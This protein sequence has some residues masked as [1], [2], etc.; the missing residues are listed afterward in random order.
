MPQFDGRSSKLS[1]GSFQSRSDRFGY[2]DSLRG[3]AALLVIYLHLAD[4]FLHTEPNLGALD[5]WSFVA[6]TEVIDIGK[7]AV[8]VFFAISGYVIPFSLMKRSDHAVRRFV[9]SR[10]FRLYPAYWLSLSAALVVLVLAA[11][12]HVDAPEVVAN[13][14]MLQQFFGIENVLGIYWTLQIELIFYALCVG[15]FIIGLLQKTKFIFSTSVIF[16]AFALVLAAVRFYSGMKL[17]VVVPLSLA[18]MFWGMIR[19][20]ADDGEDVAI[21][22][23]VAL[24]VIFAVVIP[25]VS[26]LAYNRDYGYNE[27]WYRYTISYGVAIAFFALC[28]S[29][30]RID[31]LGMRHLGRI[32]YSVYLFGPIAEQIVLL[33]LLPRLGMR[34]GAHLYIGVT[35]VLAVAMAAIIYRFVEAPSITFGRR[36]GDRISARTGLRYRDPARSAQ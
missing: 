35:M 19:R 15:L 23:D 25:L 33:S 28:S 1:S 14:T 34:Q 5:H 4:H 12:Q 21:K 9:I 7:S 17:P 20:Q 36:V 2:I 18:V 26:F 31:F 30:A 24:L 27:T 13:V 32:S 10:F 22:A 29:R 3:I 8:I 16:L 6:L 11:H